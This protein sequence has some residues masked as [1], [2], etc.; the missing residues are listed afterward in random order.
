MDLAVARVISVIS[1]VTFSVIF[2]V[3]AEVVEGQS[4]ANGESPTADIP[5]ERT[6]W[7]A[8]VLELVFD[9]GD[10]AGQRLDVPLLPAPG[11]WQEAA[12]MWPS[13]GRDLLQQAEQGGY[14]IET[15]RMLA[16]LQL[17][18]RRQLVFPVEE[19]RFVPVSRETY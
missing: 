8:D 2:L 13:E 6:L 9:S 19:L 10:R 3:A 14:R 5:S 16:P 1:S 4:A 18:D 15:R 11:T 17:Q 7:P 12:W